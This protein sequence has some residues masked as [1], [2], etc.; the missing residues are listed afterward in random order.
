M[1]CSPSAVSHPAGIGQGAQAGKLLLRAAGSDTGARTRCRSPLGNEEQRLHGA[2][3]QFAG[4]QLRLQRGL[5][6]VGRRTKRRHRIDRA[7]ADAAGYGKPGSAR[8]RT[9]GS[10]RPKSSSAHAPPRLSSSPTSIESTTAVACA[11]VGSWFSARSAL[12]QYRLGGWYTCSL[13]CLADGSSLRTINAAARGL[14][15]CGRVSRSRD[16]PATGAVDSVP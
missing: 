5:P 7:D 13:T 2:H 16:R 11:Y 3:Q 9:T 8:V 6:F 14:A 1:K 15:R 10:P 12:R 4:M